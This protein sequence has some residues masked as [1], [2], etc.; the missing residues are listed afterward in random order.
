VTLVNQA[1]PVSLV[2]EGQ[3]FS[4]WSDVAVTRALDSLADSFQLTYAAREQALIVDNRYI[5]PGAACAVDYGPHRIVTGYVN[6]SDIAIEASSYSTSCSG[7]SK[8]GDLADCAAVHKT[9]QWLQRTL[10]QIVTDL[11]QPFGIAV[12]ADPQ[13]AADTFKFSR[14]EIDE[15]ERVSDAMERLLRAT[16]VTAVSQPTGDLRLFRITGGASSGLRSVQLQVGQ[17]IS[18][19]LVRVDQDTYS[20]YR[21]RNQTGRANKE[22]SPRHA[23]LE[24]FEATDKNVTRYRPYVIGSDTHARVAELQTQATWER[25]TRAGKALTMTYTLPGGLAP[26]GQ[27]WAPPMLVLVDDRALGVRETLLLTLAELRCSNSTLE[28]RISL[29]YPEAY[30]LLPLPVRQLNKGVSLKG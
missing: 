2:V 19:G 11:C 21:L 12:T 5:Q 8:S 9:G 29:T 6:Q 26:D 18:R 15:G 28:T 20:V 14:F 30:S 13:I 10:V 7:R 3:R 17:A 22:E 4:G 24:K 23:A 16:G 25:N 1:Q 27:P